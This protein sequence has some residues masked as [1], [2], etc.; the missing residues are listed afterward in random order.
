MRHCSRE[1][2]AL[3]SHVLEFQTNLKREHWKTSSYRVHKI[4]DKIIKQAFPLLDKLVELFLCDD[5][6][7]RRCSGNASTAKKTRAS[8]DESKKAPEGGGGGVLEQ[9][10][11]TRL[12][13]CILLDMRKKLLQQDSSSSFGGVARR[14]DRDAALC[15]TRDAVLEVLSRGVY[16]LCMGP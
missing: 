10:P 13:V 16:L 5:L 14:I 8:E 1:A 3:V 7:T 15:S 2:D 11:E 6:I 9:Q 12:V 4:T